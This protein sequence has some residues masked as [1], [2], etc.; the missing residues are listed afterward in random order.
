MCVFLLV[1]ECVCVL[2]ATSH[3]LQCQLAVLGAPW[4]SGNHCPPP[5]TGV[6]TTPPTH[7]HTPA[8]EQASCLSVQL[9]LPGGCGRVLGQLPSQRA[10]SFF[11]SSA[12]FSKAVSESVRRL[13]LIATG[14]QPLG[15]LLFLLSPLDAT[16]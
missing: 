8:P 16:L 5:S 14:L 2:G 12:V 3:L 6:T 13:T 11:L 1:C 4:W 7:A 15:R 9:M 10:R